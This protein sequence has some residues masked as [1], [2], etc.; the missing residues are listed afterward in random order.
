MHFF[1]FYSFRDLTY[2]MSGQMANNVNATQAA[3]KWLDSWEIWLD[4]FSQTHIQPK[5]RS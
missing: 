3:Y 5:E 1:S 2:G 4:I